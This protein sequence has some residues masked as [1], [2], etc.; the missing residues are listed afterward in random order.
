MFPKF[1]THMSF[2][3]SILWH[4]LCS[5]EVR[6]CLFQEENLIRIAVVVN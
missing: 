6:F 5:E 4:V 2:F 1:Y 3:V